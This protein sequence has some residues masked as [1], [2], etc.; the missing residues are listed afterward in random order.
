V[1]KDLWNSSI[2]LALHGKA[3]MKQF[4]DALGAH[5]LALHRVLKTV[6]T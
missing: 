3:H 6:K 2:W 5:I 4:R 1:P